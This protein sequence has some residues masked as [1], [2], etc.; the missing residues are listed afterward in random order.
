MLKNFIVVT[1]R[2]LGRNRLYSII[3]ILGLAVGIACSLL[4]ML[5]VTDETSFDSFHPKADRLSQL[6]VNA[7]FDGKINSWNSVPLPTYEALKSAHSGIVNTVVADWGGEH[8]LTVGET[9][10]TQDGYW[11]SE[12][13]L[14]MFEFPLVV[15]NAA[16]VLDDPSSIVISQ[17]LAKSLFGEGD[18]MGQLI[19][20][21]DRSSLK[22]TGILKD[23]PQNSSFRFEYLMPWKQRELINPW[24][25]ENKTNWGNYSFQ[26]FVELAAPDKHTEVEESIK[27]MLTEH[28]ETEW[29]NE[30]FLHPLLKWRLYSNFKDGVPTG[31]M[32]D[33]V[34]LFT[35]IAIFIL[36]IACI[37]FMNLSTARSEKRAREVGI[38]KS[39]GSGRGQLIAQ[40]IGE[41]VIISF[42]AYA[43][44]I[45]IALLALP[46]Y[47][48]LVN[49][50][51]GLD[52]AS[53]AFWIYSVLV[54]LLTGIISGSYPALYLSGF[55]PVKTLK[56]SIKAGKSATTPR[57]VLVVLQFGFS[58]L[59]MISTAVIFKQI[60]LV[61][62]RELGY[63]QENLITVENTA[64]IAKNYQALKLE[65]EQSGYVE[66]VTRSNSAITNIESNNF[67]GWPGKLESQKVIF[68]TISTEYDYAKTM[69]IKVLMGR[70][71]SKE[72]STDT[73]AIVINKAA[74]DL[75]GLEDPIGTQLDLWGGKRRL[76]GV[77]DNVLMGSPYEPVK[78]MFM[79]MNP[80]WIGSIT[81]R[82]KATD[83]LQQSLAVVGEIFEKHNPAYPFEY[84]FADEEFQKK[85]TTIEM[86]RQLATLFSLLAI[87][88]T[89]L[90]LFGLASYTA[91]QRIKEI[92]VRKV[93]G[94]S[95]TSL[96]ALISKD[97]TRLVM[98]AFVL[99]APLAWYLL[100]T[101]LD[102]YTIRINIQWWIF[103]L[104]GVVALLFALAIVVNQARRA[105]L[106]NPVKS[107]RNE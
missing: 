82:L 61:K 75:M 28:G 96:V 100:D 53:P 25:V 50:Q 23:V 48:D 83:N 46:A 92:G 57:K 6:W 67:L 98:V 88:I 76:I 79:I 84:A 41:S 69:G 14:E 8:L 27:N 16:E 32:S 7:E 89:G 64:D 43:L 99:A 68:T 37:N 24:V 1:I 21:D 20:V 3:N 81:V 73:A 70:D 39:L 10:I 45:L 72:F 5:W 35:V 78:P 77:V 59:L 36:V 29:P 107:L 86:T 4:I 33:Y 52:F 91:E 40:F 103:P 30:L 71:F 90:G 42:I 15:G 106:A 102:R 62:N 60:E 19:K 85:F 56:G 93:L 12:E 94:A 44:A 11:V 17:T 101:Y 97:F 66:S 58:I 31:G 54:I 13:F 105:A 34:Q 55:S 95:V 22:V 47:N 65:L 104:A 87:F 49:K 63:D 74:L 9:R 2:N 38:R 26:V 51:L 18:P 80:N